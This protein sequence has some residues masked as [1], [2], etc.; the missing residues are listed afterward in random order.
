MNVYNFNSTQQINGRILKGK[1]LMDEAGINW[2]CGTG[3]LP[4]RSM[5]RFLLPPSCARDD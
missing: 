4:A 2:T 3:C 1:V 5:T